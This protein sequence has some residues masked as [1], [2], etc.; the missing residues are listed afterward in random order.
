MEKETKARDV[1]FRKTDFEKHG[2]TTG[3]PGCLR[4]RV[5]GAPRLHT[6]ACKYRIKE[7]LQKTP[8]WRE[9]LEQAD[10]R[11][12]VIIAENLAESDAKKEEDTTHGVYV[13]TTIRPPPEPRTEPQ[14]QSE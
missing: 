10:D 2:Y 12:T 6:K 11:Q 1:Y 8:E 3:C 7:E 5:N 13:G 14:P 9:R 4:L